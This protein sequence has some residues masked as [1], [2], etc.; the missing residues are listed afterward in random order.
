MCGKGASV[1]GS[2]FL[3]YYLYRMKEDIR[4]INVQKLAEWLAEEWFEKEVVPFVDP[5][6]LYDDELVEG[7]GLRVIHGIS[8]LY[9]HR[10]WSKVDEIYDKIIDKFLCNE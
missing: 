10:Y 4:R 5:K 7:H 9:A 3:F 8:G 1:K 2:S 6:E